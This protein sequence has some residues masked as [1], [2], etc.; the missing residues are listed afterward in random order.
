[1]TA[2][3][4]ENLRE[5]VLRQLN[6]ARKRDSEKPFAGTPTSQQMF[7]VAAEHLGIMAG[8]LLDRAG[9]ENAVF[10]AAVHLLEWLEV[11]AL[12]RVEERLEG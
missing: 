10:E 5:R 7:M 6:A 3:L 2:E 8:S 1:M 4:Q 11:L 12:A 9:L